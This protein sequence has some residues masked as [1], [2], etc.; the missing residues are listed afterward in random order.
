MSVEMD[1]RKRLQ[2]VNALG[3]ANFRVSMGADAE[4]QISTVLAALVADLQR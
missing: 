3:E 4:I 1:E 2:V